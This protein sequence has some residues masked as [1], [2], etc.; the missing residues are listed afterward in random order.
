MISLSFP[1]LA[2]YFEIKIRVQ[3]LIFLL[4]LIVHCRQ[5][6]GSYWHKC[7]IWQLPC[8]FWQNA[9][10][11]C[12]LVSDRDKGSLL[13][14]AQEGRA[15]VVPF[16]HLTLALGFRQAVIERCFDSH[17][18]TFASVFIKTFLT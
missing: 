16:S 18:W 10:P 17:Q 13:K 4:V 11:M 15:V 7:E 3:W 14:R 8:T 9:D 1:M 6:L 12:C 2:M 5:S